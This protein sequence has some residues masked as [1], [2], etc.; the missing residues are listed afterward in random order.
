[1][2]LLST[3]VAAAG[4]RARARR[5]AHPPR[6]SVASLPVALLALVAV[7]AQAE[8]YVFEGRLDEFDQ[9]ANGVYDIR[10][11][12][13]A[14]DSAALPLAEAIEYPAVEVRD[15][16]FRLDVELP[17]G[18]GLRPALAVAV[19]AS[20]EV[21]D[22]SALPGRTRVKSGPVGQCWST[23]GDTEVIA[24]THFLG[25][26]DAAPLEFRVNG[27]HAL[28]LEAS[29]ANRGTP[30]LVAGTWRNN[31]D[32]ALS[33]VVIAGGGSEDG[34]GPN[35]AS[36]SY[37]V[38]G[39]GIGNRTGSWYS[40]VAGGAANAASGQYA[41][42]SGGHGNLADGGFATIAGGNTNHVNGEFGTIGGGMN[43]TITGIGGTISGGYENTAKSYGSVGGG[44]FNSAPA[45][46]AT[47]AGGQGNCAGGSYS[48]AGGR[49]AKVRP[50]ADAERNSGCSDVPSSSDP[51]GD[52]GSFVWAGD[53]GASSPFVSSGVN[54][55]LVRATGGFSIN[56]NII[57]SNLDLV[58]GSRTNGANVDLTLAS[59]GSTT[60]VNFGVNGSGALFVA[61]VGLP[62]ASSNP[63]TFT[64]YAQWTETG[65]FRLFIDNPIKPTNGGFS[66]PS[67]LRL[68]H[69]IEPLDG[70]LGRLLQLDGVRFEYLP[71]APAAYYTPGT[72][73]GFIAQQVE[74]VFPDWVSTDAAGYK[75]VGAKGFEPLAI[76][77]L[78][79]LHQRLATVEAERD[80]LQARL[81]R[82]EAALDAWLER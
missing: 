79:E 71:D 6:P 44:V 40:T 39:G 34:D 45:S 38:I 69:R 66:A 4:R 42:V 52:R 50:A 35:I 56:R 22:Y 24:G 12:P 63:A 10:I 37:S 49:G 53:G 76:E 20:G 68:K 57:P 74:Q 73:T 51:G 16:R 26:L 27:Y 25:T 23:T 70:A 15:G 78:R 59:T 46:H 17:P 19:R 7:S 48:F 41:I 3:C 81:A 67:D 13:F 58:L 77:S 80:A 55:F 5:A 47:V 82:L 60:G 64:D 30:N 32:N 21:A 72:H 2:S 61:R 31:A 33:G 75:L 43:N 62:T 36:G 11:T 1:M 29:T 65:V 9:P 28:K 18:A 54:Q 8:P 14:S